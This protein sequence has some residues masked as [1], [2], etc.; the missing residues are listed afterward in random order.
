[1]FIAMVFVALSFAAMVVGSR[2]EESTVTEQALDALPPSVPTHRG[3][4]G[5]WVVADGDADRLTFDPVAHRL[6]ARGALPSYVVSHVLIVSA[7]KDLVAWADALEQ[8]TRGATVEAP[9]VARVPASATGF[10]LPFDP[11]EARDKGIAFDGSAMTFT[12]PVESPTRTALAA[13]GAPPEL[14]AALEGLGQRSEEAKVSGVWLLLSYLFATL[15]ELC[16]SPVGLS[17]VT[18]LA[19][20]QYASVFMGVWMLASSVGQYAGGSIGESWGIITPTHY[21]TLFVWTSLVG[22]AVLA[23]LVRPLRRMMHDVT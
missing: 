11:T 17:M 6:R 9:V 14:R 21:F 5:S 3:A 12:R 19:P 10:T 8:A 15:G 7:P 1:M 13:A 20:V 4:D 16:L 18:K 23:L 2:F 22:A